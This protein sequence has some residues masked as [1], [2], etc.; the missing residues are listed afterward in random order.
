MG[1]IYILILALIQGITEFL[2]ISSSGHL[3]LPQA[4][5]PGW[6]SLDAS[7]ALSFD[8]AVH[9][10]T[11]GAVMLYFRKDV[12]NLLLG[13]SNSIIYR[14]HTNDS[15]LAWYL[16]IATIPAAL[17]GLLF[18]DLIKNELRTMD[19]VAITSIVFGLLLGIADK[20]KGNTDDLA[21]ITLKV[22][23]I[24]GIAQAVALIPGTSRSGITI[25]AALFCGLSR[26]SAARFSFLLAMPIIM[27]SGG[28]QALTL[29]QSQSVIW[30]DLLY[31][32]VISF[33]SAL[34]CIH[35]FLQFINKIGMMPFVVYRLLL[36]IILLIVAFTV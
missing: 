23:L 26:T 24:I 7:E 20:R 28:Y 19:V 34:I 30:S 22:A 10:G 13:W 14:K 12:V 18:N 15:R 1:F 6:P 17:F 2:P 33:V 29:V 25:T 31:G 36:G 16:I 21:Q 32:A 27:L 5:I 3:L 4:L 9:V 35:Y 11:L 8:V